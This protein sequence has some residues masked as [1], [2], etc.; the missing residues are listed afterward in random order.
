ML[1]ISRDPVMQLHDVHDLSKEQ[2]RER[3]MEKIASMRHY[4]KEDNKAF[5]RRMQVVGLSDAGFQTRFGVSIGL[6][7]GA[8]RNGATKE[9]WGELKSRFTFDPLWNIPLTITCS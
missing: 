4:V 2:L 7:L 1:Q 6:F 3:T 8:I 9:Q 5:A